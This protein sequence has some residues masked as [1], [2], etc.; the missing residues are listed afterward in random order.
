MSSK[1]LRTIVAVLLLATLALSLG[2][3][4]AMAPEPQWEKDARAMLDH[5]ESLF[6]KK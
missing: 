5:I 3:A 4:P 1:L 6:V 2:C